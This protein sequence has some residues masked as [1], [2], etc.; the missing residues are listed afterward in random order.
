M[1]STVAT[2]GPHAPRPFRQLLQEEL[3]RRCN[4]NPHYSLRAFA[5]DLDCDH[6]SLSQLLRGRRRLTGR[7]LQTLGARLGLDPES[8]AAYA[9]LEDCTPRTAE[10]QGRTATVEQLS[11]DALAVLADPLHHALLELTHLEGFRPDVAWIGRVLGAE[12]DEVQVAVQRLV[13]LG[14]L[15]MA[16]PDRWIDRD[17]HRTT[18]VGPS[19]WRALRQ[20]AET[21][22]LRALGEDG[23]EPPRDGEVSATT[24]AVDRRRIPEALAIL[25]RARR[26][27]IERLTAPG[28]KDAVYHLETSLLPLTRDDEE[29]NPCPTP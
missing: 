29:S 3:L 27:L 2:P 10:D 21:V 7:M 6:A 19:A 15:E 5:R 4:D 14:L 22:R 20:L 24:L 1:K 23:P 28:A 18:V 13:R 12:P 8:L 9:A 26:E 25:A 17:G 11:A 16:G